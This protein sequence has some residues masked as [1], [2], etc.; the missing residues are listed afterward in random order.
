MPTEEG[1]AAGSIHSTGSGSMGSVMD[2]ADDRHA[3]PMVLLNPASVL[4]I[5]TNLAD[6]PLVYRKPSV[7][8]PLSYRSADKCAPTAV[9]GLLRTSPSRIRLENSLGVSRKP[10][11]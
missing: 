8:A 7:E 9:G 11:V 2:R 5:S 6:V 10:N 1:H 3:D 4:L